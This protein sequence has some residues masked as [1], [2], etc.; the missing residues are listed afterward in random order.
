[1]PPDDFLR[2][3]QLLAEDA[4][5]ILEQV[6]QRL[7][8]DQSHALRQAA[9]VVMRLDRM[10]V[11]ILGGRTLDYVRVQG[12]VDD[13]LIVA[14]LAGLALEN[15]DEPLADDSAF[16]L[17]VDN[18]IES[19]EELRAGVDEYELAGRTGQ[20]RPREPARPRLAQETVIYEYTCQ[21][22]PQSPL[23]NRRGDRGIDA[24]GQGTDR[25]VPYLLARGPMIQPPR[26]ARGASNRRCSRIP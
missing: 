24:A 20:R 4:H 22:V 13:V 2:Q 21:P 18:A 15:A 5:L 17:R 10:R 19:G 16:P 9:D 25:A 11:R 7:D 3:A 26:R 23:G 6:A 8:V 14:E 12:S 1:M